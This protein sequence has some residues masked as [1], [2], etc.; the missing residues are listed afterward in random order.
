MLDFVGPR[1]IDGLKRA[2]NRLQMAS[3][4][5]QVHRRINQL[6][7]S[8]QHLNRPQICTGLQ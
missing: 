7:M 3:R 5:M 1:Y 4:Q 2:G 6:G 8:E